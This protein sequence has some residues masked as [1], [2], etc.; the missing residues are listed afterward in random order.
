VIA[1]ATIGLIV[2]RT[3]TRIDGERPDKKRFVS[4]GPATDPEG[5]GVGLGVSASW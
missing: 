4:I 5:R 2:G 1:G 3:V